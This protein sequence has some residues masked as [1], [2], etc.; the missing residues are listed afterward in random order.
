MDLKKITWI[1]RAFLLKP[2]FGSLGILSYIGKPVSLLNKKNIFIGRN[3]HIYPGARIESYQGGKIQIEDNV[4][5]SENVH[6]VSSGG[7]L[8]IGRGTL[9][10]PNVFI[11]NSD[12]EYRDISQQVVKQP[13]VVQKVEIG[14]ENYI[15]SGVAILP[16]T[17]TGIHTIIGANSVVLKEYENYS[18]I[19]GAP[20]K[21]VKKYDKKSREWK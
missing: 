15:G 17:I 14:S 4:S 1:V 13:L 12:H 19:V 16:G 8:I 18:V 20:G 6:I 5:I 2:W 7:T 9:I 3:V 21:V 11:S 10:G